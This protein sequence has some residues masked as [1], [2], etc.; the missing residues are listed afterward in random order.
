MKISLLIILTCT[1][2]INTTAQSLSGRIIQNDPYKTPLFGATVIIS[3]LGKGEI[4]GVSGNFEIP[5]VPSGT[6]H[7]KVSFIGFETQEVAIAVPLKEPL[8]IALNEDLTRL[9]D[10]EIRAKALPT[11]QAEQTSLSTIKV[12]DLPLTAIPRLLGEPDLIRMIQNL[13][14]VKTESDFTGGFSVRGGRN[15]Q[16]LLLLDGVPIYNPWHLFGLFSAFNTEA[17]ES[18]EFTKGVFPSQYGSRVSSVLDIK[19][20][21]GDE[22]LGAGHLTVSPISA[23]FS[24]GR[25]INQKTSYLIAVRR[26]YMDPVFWAANVAASKEDDEKKDKVKTGYNF[27]DLN[28][29]IVHE[30][31]PGLKL[32]TGFFVGNDVLDLGYTLKYKK[33]SEY[34]TSNL[35][36]GWTNLTGSAKLIKKTEFGSSTSHLFVSK[37]KAENAYKEGTGNGSWSKD[38]ET[39]IRGGRLEGYALTSQFFE[40]SFTQRFTDLGLQQDFSFHLNDNTTLALGGQWIMHQ[41]D[42]YSND[43]Q[44]E[45]GFAYAEDAPFPSPLP[46]SSLILNALSGDTITTR[47]HELSTYANASIKLGRME[48]YPGVRLQHFDK[49]NYTHLLPRVNAKF[50]LTDDLFF[51]AGY[52]H[53]TQYLQTVGLDVIRIPAERWF[54]STENRKPLFA[55]TFTAGFGYEHQKLGLFSV[56]GYYRT[57]DGLLS[58]STEKQ[59]EALQSEYIPRFGVETLSGTGEAYGLELLWNKNH[60]AV[61]GWFGYTLS[62]VW[63]EFDG[64]NNGERFPSRTDKRH[65]IQ[66]FWTYDLNNNW[67]FGALFNFKTGQPLTYSSGK[68]L[69]EE[70]PLG[71]GD[72]SGDNRVITSLNNFRLPAYHRLDVSITW[73][74]RNVFKHKSEWSLNVVNVYNRLNVL[75]AQSGGSVEQLPNGKIRIRPQN[76]YVGQLPIVPMLSLRIGLGKDAK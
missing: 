1:V 52:G 71:V 60:G 15:D 76:K 43:K 19:L 30:F 5:K 36:Y 10:V 11:V 28:A 22:R 64:L 18:V 35:T 74:N 38:G 21:D 49:G 56:E 41:L 68:Y 66:T 47:A 42:E 70:D 54:W 51:A 13:P 46:S 72:D 6:Y 65:D 7:L 17:L 40:E 31:K 58:F 33:N 73:K 34:E 2:T 32:E 48:L 4:S 53:F 9:N 57:L 12:S 59:A 24:Y 37:Y 14:G 26:T 16:N 45:N 23:S 44:V 3:E 61:K 27:L 39:S 8:I 63:N 20:Q 67:S 29:K 69:V 55:R 62:W 25:P 75:N 50:H